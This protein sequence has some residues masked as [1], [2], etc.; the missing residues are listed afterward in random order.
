MPEH[1]QFSIENARSF[2]NTGFQPLLPLTLL[3]GENSSGKTSFFALLYEAIDFFGYVDPG[4]A[5]FDLGSFED[6]VYT[7]PVTGKRGSHYTLSFQ[8]ERALPKLSSVLGRN[9]SNICVSITYGEYRGNRVAEGV[10]LRFD[11]HYLAIATNNR[12]ITTTIRMPNF[13]VT[14]KGTSLAGRPTTDYYTG[15]YFGVRR[16]LN[17]LCGFVSG[18]EQQNNIRFAIQGSTASVMNLQAALFKAIED[19]FD[20][21]DE[22]F[23]DL[24]I[25]TAAMRSEP[26]RVY[27]S[28][29]TAAGHGS[30]PHALYRLQQYDPAIWSKVRKG[31]NE[32]GRS[33]GLF[34]DIEVKSLKGRRRSGPFEIIVKRGGISSNLMDVGYGVSQVLPFISDI[35]MTDAYTPPRGMRGSRTYYVQQPETH[36]HPSAQAAIGSFFFNLSR[37]PGRRV[38]LETHS[39]FIVDRIRQHVRTCEGDCTKETGLIFF[40]NRSGVSTLYPISFDREGNVIGAPDHYREFFLKEEFRNLGASDVLDN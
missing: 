13:N 31:L 33:S 35:L 1:I 36:L 19:T 40:E 3:V 2:K 15:S 14:V 4:A 21:M 12:T 10:T 8:I 26:Q 39:D 17:A 22:D 29:P 27:A 11:Q 18:K 6:V 20:T 24:V 28:N 37:Q 32:F 30:T 34:D 9:I 16:F 38:I 7:D 5:F 23:Q 25:P